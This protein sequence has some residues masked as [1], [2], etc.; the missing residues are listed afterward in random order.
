V[1][2]VGKARPQVIEDDEHQRVF[3]KVAA[4][5]VAKAT[6]M[7]CVRLPGAGGR[8]RASKVWEVTAVMG[9]VTDLGRQ[10]ARDGIEMVTL[11]ATSDY[12]RIWY[13]VLEMCG[14]AVQLVDP[15]QARNIKGRPK[16]DK[17]DAMWLARL[18]EWGMLRP[19]FVPPAPVRVLRDYARARADLVRER[20]RCFQRL[21]KLLE[22]ALIKL[23][24]VASKLTTRSAKD[25]IKAMIAGERDPRALAALARTS[26][27]AKHAALVQA[28]DGMFDS[29]HGELAQLELDQIAFLDTRIT[30][31]E[32]RIAAVLAEIPAAWG[33]D[34]DGST[35]PDAGTGPDAIVLPAARRLAEIEGISVLTA[36]QIIAEVGLDM[37][38]FPTAAHLVSWAGLCP[39]DSQSGRSRKKRK[40]HGNT[41]LRGYLGQAATGASSTSTFL[42]ERYRRIA[43]R[44]GKAKAQ[45]AVARS[46]LIIIWHLLND[47]TA[48]YHDLGP[49]YVAGRTS[50]DKK[51]RNHIRGLRALDLTDQEI[52]DI[53]TAHQAA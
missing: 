9:A 33:I 37:A 42:G 7:V 44:R 23:S 46:I 3:E 2:A 21:E 17:L 41:Y 31:A 36:A 47:P 14:L 20:T 25:M 39:V 11:E 49:D 30:W 48:R 52:T 45:V 1:T 22:D 40:G 28:L 43:R 51:I 38:R 18:T 19:C 34:A 16:T 8:P 27:K 53:L 13:Y 32:N 15:A 26:M 10:L 24:S 12:W 29:H 35:G 6:G 4:V 5:D 50:R